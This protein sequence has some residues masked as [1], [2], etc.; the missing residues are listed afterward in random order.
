MKVGEAALN[1]DKSISI[2]SFHLGKSS[3]EL[4]RL[5]VD[6]GI[7]GR[8]S[9]PPL[10]ETDA[11]NLDRR[12]CLDGWAKRNERGAKREAEDALVDY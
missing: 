12:L 11:R 9:S 10:Q 7:R 4:V 6:V 2:F 8:R 3:P 1:Q 5:K